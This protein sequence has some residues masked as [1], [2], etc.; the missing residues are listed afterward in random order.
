[1]IWP[2]SLLRSVNRCIG[3][4]DLGLLN[5]S[6][7]KKLTWKFMTSESFGFS[8]LRERYLTQLRKSH[9]ENSQRDFWRDNWLGVPI[10]ELLGIL[11]YFATLIKARVSDF[12]YEGKWVL[13][14][15][16]RVRFPDLYSRIDSVAISLVIDSLV[17]AHSRDGQFSCKSV[18]SC[19]IRDSPQVLWWK[20][21]WCH[22]NAPSRSALTWR[23]LLNRLPIEDRLCRV[24][25]HLAFRYSVYGVSSESSDHLFIRCSLAVAL[26]E[27]VFSAFQRLSDANQL[28]IGC[29]RNCVDDLLILHRFDLCGRPTKAPFIRSVIWSPLAPGWTKVITDGAVLSSPGAGGCGGIFRN[30]RAFVKGCFAVPL[31]HVFAFEAE[32]LAA[33]ITINFAWQNGWHRICL[34]SDSSYVVHLLSS[35]SEQVPWRIRQAWQH[36]I[37]QISKMEFQFLISLGRG[38]RLQTL[39]LSKLWG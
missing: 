7:L 5:D 15:N 8:F 14:D 4:K 9:G 16:F 34:E 39:F 20:D 10:L 17:W 35:H 13:D 25:F 29:M 37:Y 2:S 27:A 31:D 1:M 6:L 32:L 22:F 19:M 36:F 12:I 38:I 33:S 26:W 24:G 11:D 3:L 23:L 18:Y 28:K 30:C 21:V